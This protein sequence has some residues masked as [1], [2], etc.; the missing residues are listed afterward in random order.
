[1]KLNQNLS[2]DAQNLTKAL[3][4]ENKTQGNWGEL[5]LEKVLESSGL[6]KGLEYITQ[7]S[8]TNDDGKRIQPDVVVLL[9]DDKNIIIDSKVSLTAYESY[10]SEENEDLRNSHLNNHLISVKNHIKNLSEKNYQLA[11]NINTPDF[12]LLFMPIESAFSL[13]LQKDNMLYNYAWDRKIV[14]VSPTTLLATLKTIASIWK[15]DKQTKNA[16]K[17]ADEAGKMYDKFVGFVEDMLKI[18]NGISATKK[19]YDAAMNKLQEGRGNLINKAQDIQ[20]LGISNSKQLPQQILS[21][22]EV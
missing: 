4:G 18:E 2:E 13:A 19:S 14:I 11:K 6:E 3:K 1:M 5:I 20:K 15:Q 16:F 12:V 9:P 10:I 8:S 22:D 17:I 7:V 21:D